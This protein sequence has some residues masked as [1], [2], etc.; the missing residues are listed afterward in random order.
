[1]Q[2]GETGL[3][4]KT[5]NASFTVTLR[6]DT[7]LMQGGPIA[8]ECDPAFWLRGPSVRG[9]LHTWARALIGPFA[10]GDA[11]LTRQAELRLLGGAGGEDSGVIPTF[12]YSFENGGLEEANNWPNV[13]GANN[14]GFRPAHDPEQQVELRFA[15]RPAVL[16]G[17]HAQPFF[18][19]ALWAVVWS[20]FAFGSLGARARR[21]YGSL[22][23]CHYDAMSGFALDEGQHTLPCFD[24]SQVPDASQLATQ[25]SMG[26][27]KAQAALHAWL[28]A[29]GLQ[30][31]FTPPALSMPRDNTFPFFQLALSEQVA[32]G[33]ERP[34]GRKWNETLMATCHDLAREYKKEYEDCFGYARGKL[35]MASPLW[36]R[37]YNTDAGYVPVLTYARRKASRKETE[38][39]ARFLEAL[40]ATGRTL[41][42]FNG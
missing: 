1:V 6:I 3:V 10:G 2:V 36:V 39:H 22:T 34:V 25:L 5:R 11:G 35:R 32:V 28:C 7:P 23:L 20:A 15:P 24:F 9:L 18:R 29:N 19:E 33:A 41:D 14:K 21:G 31:K 4:G 13:P 8:R 27:Q 37:L 40:G 12:R 42:T 38:M 30:P 16:T 26:L 17:E